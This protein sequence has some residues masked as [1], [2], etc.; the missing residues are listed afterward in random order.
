MG[1]D[2]TFAG[3]LKVLIN[4]FN[5][6]CLNQILLCPSLKEMKFAFMIED[7]QQEY[8]MEKTV[9]SIGQH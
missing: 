2:Y 6:Y 1:C 7:E 9:P 4:D 5:Q 8:L 3:L